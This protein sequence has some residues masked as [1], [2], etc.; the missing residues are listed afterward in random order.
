MDGDKDGILTLRT[1]AIAKLVET[2]NNEL[3]VAF[4]KLIWERKS[5]GGTVYF[6]GNGASNTIADHASLDYMSQ[7]GV[8]T[9]TISNPSV[10]TAFSNDF[11]YEK[12]L[13]RFLQIQFHDTDLLVVVSS[14]GNS[15][16]VV[17]AADY[18][19]SAGGKV[20]AFTGFNQNNRL[21]AI[22]DLNFYVESDVYNVVESVHNAWLASI[23]D[24]LA[25]WMGED[26]GIHGIELD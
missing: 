1:S 13:R 7:T 17:L 6:A 10:L 11:S 21:A 19:Q 20:V 18:V 23:C 9:H 14:S 24:L 26:V 16:N 4:A 22:A 5:T 25:H 2:L 15:E 8:R 12:A 3:A